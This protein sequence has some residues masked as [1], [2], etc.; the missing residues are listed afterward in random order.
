MVF[1]M[2]M[3]IIKKLKDVRLR[4][5]VLIQGLP[6]IGFV[7][8]IAVDYILSELK[9]PKVAELYSDGLLLPIGNAGVYIDEKGVF[10]VPCYKFHLLVGEERDLLFLSSEVQPVSWSQYEVADKVLEYFRSIGGE[11]VVAVCGTTAREGEK[12]EVYYAVDCE[13]TAKWLDKLGFK[14]SIGGTITG[15]C[16]LLPALAHLK[17]MKS[18]VLMGTT[19]SA[20]PDPEAG[21]VIVKALIKIFGINVS[22]DNLSKI[23]E[24]IRKKKKEMEEAKAMLKKEKPESQPPYYV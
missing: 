7:G 13:E 11:E 23:I 12:K 21:M 20:E 9:L 6:G 17:G 22:L 2:G 19:A 4:H 16:G 10:S 18:Y 3:V 15:A 24:E 5:G 8:K 14:R 1:L